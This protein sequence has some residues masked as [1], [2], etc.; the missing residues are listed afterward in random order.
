MITL[1]TGR[2]QSGKS[3]IAR[4][5]ANAFSDKVVS[6]YEQDFI[7]NGRSVKLATDTKLLVIDDAQF[8]TTINELINLS[9]FLP[10]L[11]IVICSQTLTRNDLPKSGMFRT[12]ECTYH[13]N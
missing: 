2:A 4:G 11:T 10:E 12:I 8:Q 5:M 3:F 9:K 1:I 13:V 6:V 7:K